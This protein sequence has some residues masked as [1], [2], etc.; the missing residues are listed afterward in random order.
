[1]VLTAGR[2][3]KP[4][5]PDFSERIAR[6]ELAKISPKSRSAGAYGR[7]VLS[8]RKICY[9]GVIPSYFWFRF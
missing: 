2:F 6:D 8:L 3:P 4:P 5:H 7:T 9:P 1:M